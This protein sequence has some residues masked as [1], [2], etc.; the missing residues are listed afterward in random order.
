MTEQ[1]IKCKVC[2]KFLGTNH[3]DLEDGIIQIGQGNNSPLI[4]LCGDDCSKKHEKREGKVKEFDLNN[5][6]K[7]LKNQIKNIK[8]EL[9]IK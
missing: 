4:T 8:S 6:I 3:R 2:G 9:K 5:K 7:R 1:D